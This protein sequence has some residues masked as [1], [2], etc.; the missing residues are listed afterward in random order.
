MQIVDPVDPESSNLLK[1][2]LACFLLHEIN[3][4]AVF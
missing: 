1:Q 4:S 3:D 2:R